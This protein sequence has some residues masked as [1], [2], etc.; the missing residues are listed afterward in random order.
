VTE[1]INDE[2]TKVHIEL[3]L[4]GGPLCPADLD[5]EVWKAV[6]AN[7]STTDWRPGPEYHPEYRDAR[8]AVEAYKKLITS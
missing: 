4:D 7:Y 6:A 1:P 2:L 5:P 8:A 3:M